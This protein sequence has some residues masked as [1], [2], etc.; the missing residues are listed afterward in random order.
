MTE[1]SKEKRSPVIKDRMN[2]IFAV[3]AVAV[4]VLT[5][6][7]LSDFT[8]D[9]NDDVLMKDILSG[10]YSGVPESRNIQM[11]WPLSALI[12][13]LYSITNAVPWYGLFLT[14]CQ[15]GSLGLILYRILGAYS[16]HE[17]R[18]SDGAP[19]MGT[20]LK[21]RLWILLF[22]L[23]FFGGIL[24]LHLIFLQYTIT[25]AIISG[26]AIV[27][28]MTSDTSQEMTGLLKE[29]I[30]AFI[31]IFLAF[32]LRSE[33]LLLMLPFICV[34]GI[35]KWIG[36]EKIMTGSNC[37]KYFSV[38][39]VIIALLALGFG[40]DKAAYDPQDWKEFRALFDARTE[41]YDFQEIPSYEGNEA[42]YEGIG[43]S[44]EERILLENYNYGLSDKIDTKTLRMVAEHSASLRTEEKSYGEKLWE[45]IRYYIYR[46]T[47][48]K[49]PG[50]DRPYNILG[51]LLYLF[52]LLL[53]LGYHRKNGGI[54]D[55]LTLGILFATRTLVWMYIILGGR[56]PDR[57]T[58]SL[59]FTEFCI[60]FCLLIKKFVITEKAFCEEEQNRK[61]NITLILYA[62]LCVTFVL[63]FWFAIRNAAKEDERR[64]E[65]NA[66]YE[67]LCGYMKNE[68]G[69][70]YLM[71]V[72]STVAYS[73]KVF[74]NR[75]DSFRNYDLLG[76]WACFSPVQEKKLIRGIG[77]DAMD[78]RG[79]GDD[80]LKENVYF[81]R[82]KEQDMDWLPAYYQ[83]QGTDASLSLEKEIAGKFEIW[84]V[85]GQ[86]Q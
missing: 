62:L 36:E 75:D 33:M 27:W 63:Q 2:F 72:Y 56:E 73:E 51:I 25:V 84:K 83:S 20:I 5:A 32:L 19:D 3:S 55:A 68:S 42:F 26:A 24:F 14:I 34:A 29:N 11:L 22:S 39:G 15:F 70:F 6:S 59:Y 85:T 64:S 4:L 21:N 13:G 47:H 10:A 67:E 61:K 86:D 50:T 12:A 41:L 49:G 43:L 76:G 74:R 30:P 52:V 80:L 71:D 60:L 81:V 23:F 79:M 65:V 8:Y 16:L 66:P 53:S 17:K 35:S 7:L 40:A 18:P 44:K 46:L 54:T 37:K 57:I 69:S 78:R 28:F 9:L 1:E 58:H 48:F 31:L 82:D 38:F 77:E 45:G